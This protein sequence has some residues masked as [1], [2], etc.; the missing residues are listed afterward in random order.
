MAARGS[1]T[2]SGHASG[3]SYVNFITET[4]GRERAAFGA[5]Y[6]RL[7]EVKNTYDPTNLFRL[8]QNVRPTV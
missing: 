5:N 6:D 3:G 7:V 8:N 1:E 4:E 2:L